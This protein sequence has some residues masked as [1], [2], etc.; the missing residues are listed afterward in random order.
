MWPC[1]KRARSAGG[2]GRG[3]SADA[4]DML[5]AHSPVLRATKFVGQSQGKQEKDRGFNQKEQKKVSRTT[6]SRQRRTA[7]KRMGCQSLTPP[8]NQRIQGG[9]IQYTRVDVD[10][11]GG[12]GYRRGGL[13]G[14]LRYAQAEHQAGEFRVGPALECLSRCRTPRAR[15]PRNVISVSAVR[16]VPQ[17]RCTLLIPYS[18]PARLAEPARY[19]STC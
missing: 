11:R 19:A 13:C 15:L 10:W 5:N 18:R 16:R 2:G 1:R 12:L 3:T 17:A 6:G 8:D 14:D 4:Q 9:Q 7:V